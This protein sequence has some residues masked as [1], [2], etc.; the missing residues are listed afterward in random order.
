MHAYIITGDFNIHAEDPLDSS[1]RQFTD[2]SSSTNLTQHVSVSTHIH[3]YTLDLV[4]TSSHI[5]LSSTISQSFNSESNHFSIFT[6]LNLT[7]TPPP[8]PSK[9]TFH[10]TK[11][12]NIIKFNNELISSD[13]ILHPPTSLPELHDSYDSTIHSILDKL[14]T[15]N[16]QNFT[17]ITPGTFIFTHSK[18]CSPS[19][20]MQIQLYSFCFRLYNAMQSNKPI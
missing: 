8:S 16:F 14:L 4:I 11:V 2:I 1:S 19:S 18:I 17:N 7:P 15:P 13:L 6:H 12:I 9:I 5:N 3:Y 10:R 20:R